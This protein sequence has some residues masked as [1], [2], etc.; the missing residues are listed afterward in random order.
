M[1]GSDDALGQFQTT[2]LELLERHPDGISEYELFNQL[3]ALNFP[4]YHESV[5]RATLG[6][7]RAHFALFHA[8]YQLRDRLWDEQ[9]AQLDINTLC[10]RLSPYCAQHSSLPSRRDP[11]RDY[12]L[13][14]RHLHETTASDVA[15]LLGRF[16]RRF[17][18]RD[19]REQA[20]GVLG[21]NDPVDDATIKQTWRRLAMLH[22]PDRGGSE[23]R[24]QEI[25]AALTVLLG[26]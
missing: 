4:D 8:L 9:R 10:I 12:Y 23:Q 5:R 20:L 11:L 7:F 14:T 1:S 21:L 3:A 2:L 15:D 18:P 6:L 16:W 19:Q 22:H 17:G 26:A 13:D 25:N 24:L